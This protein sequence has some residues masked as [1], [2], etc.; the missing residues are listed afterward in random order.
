MT[1]SLD[2]NRW[3]QK[4]DFRGRVTVDHEIASQNTAQLLHYLENLR[5]TREWKRS[6]VPSAHA[7]RKH[8]PCGRENDQNQVPGAHHQG[9]RSCH[10]QQ[11]HNRL[12]IRSWWKGNSFW[13]FSR[14]GLRYQ[15][16]NKEEEEELCKSGKETDWT[17]ISKEC[18][19]VAPPCKWRQPI[20][21]FIKFLVSLILKTSSFFLKFMLIPLQRRFSETGGKSKGLKEMVKYYNSESLKQLRGFPSF[22]IRF[23]TKNEATLAAKRHLWLSLKVKPNQF[24]Y[25]D[26]SCALL[27]LHDLCISF[28]WKHRKLLQIYS[29]CPCVHLDAGVGDG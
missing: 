14:S 19:E 8:R 25:S 11:P 3:I 6:R 1:N 18:R 5:E 15:E 29:C 13:L 16:A 10:F 28:R 7:P 27:G 21:S 22:K 9:S 2:C 23:T 20:S 12:R 4:H 24:A 26:S 17:S